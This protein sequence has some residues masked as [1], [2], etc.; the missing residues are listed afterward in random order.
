[1]YRVLLSG[2][3]EARVDWLTAGRRRLEPVDRSELVKLGQAWLSSTR[4]AE[5]DKVLDWIEERVR[6]RDA[7]E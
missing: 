1:V 2:G 5:A 6:I 7:A 3:R 4:S